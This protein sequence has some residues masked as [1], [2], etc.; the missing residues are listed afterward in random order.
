MVEKPEPAKAP[1]NLYI[2]GRYIL[3]PGIFDHPR[4]PGARRRQ[5]D[6]AHRRH[7][8]A[9]RDAALLRLP[10]QRP[11]L[12]LRH[13]ARLSRRQR[14]ARAET[15]RSRRPASARNSGS[16]SHKRAGLACRARSRRRGKLL[17]RATRAVEGRTGWRCRTRR[18][19]RSRRSRRRRDGAA[20]SALGARSASS[21]TG[22]TALAS[23][24]ED[25]L[26][27]PFAGGRRPD[28]HLRRQGHRQRRRQ[29]RPYR[30]EDRRDP[31]LDRHAG[32]LRSSR[33]GEPRRPRHDHA[34]TT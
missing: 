24:L 25:G 30:A 32:L 17:D 23:A 4:Q 27:A 13:Q 11:D 29:E 22:L 19:G 5:R 31:R 10:L 3:Q 33:R 28:P 20:A 21:A 6:P 26:A 16:C 18:S 14:R 2:N 7:D 9:R 8:P 15:G 12:R 34:R 1:S